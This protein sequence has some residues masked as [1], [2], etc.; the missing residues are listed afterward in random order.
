M[1]CPGSRE[2]AGMSCS[3]L[4]CRVAGGGVFGC[5]CVP[6]WSPLCSESGSH[7]SFC[8]PPP[9]AL[10]SPPPPLLL[11]LCPPSLRQRL[12]PHHPPWLLWVADR[13]DTGSRGYT[14][15]KPLC[16]RSLLE[17]GGG[18]GEVSAVL[19]LVLLHFRGDDNPH[20]M[21]PWQ[22]KGGHN[23][24]PDAPLVWGEGE[25]GDQRNMSE[26]TCKGSQSKSLKKGRNMGEMLLEY[27][28]LW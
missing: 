15:I 9:Q 12:P 6:W 22:L 10:A 19:N 18:G 16:Y 13:G 20:V 8:P 14:I 2:S 5:V 27:R 7:A 25:G 17:G 4:W 28:C 21:A 23:L 24:G 3:R 1:Q 11:L 26:Q